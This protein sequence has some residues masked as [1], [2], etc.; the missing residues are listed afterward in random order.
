MGL[1]EGTSE[2]LPLRF[3][4]CS[5]GVLTYFL[6]VLRQTEPNRSAHL[7]N[8]AEYFVHGVACL[9]VQIDLGQRQGL[10]EFLFRS[11]DVSV[12]FVNGARHYGLCPH[13]DL[14]VALNH[15]SM[16]SAERFQ[17]GSHEKLCAPLPELKAPPETIV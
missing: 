2:G 3:Q 9:F 13:I 8:C 12:P 6:V 17:L 16:Q 15:C 14:I 10:E 11:L 7:A 4:Y 1:V 5:V